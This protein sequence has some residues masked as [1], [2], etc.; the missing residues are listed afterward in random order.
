LFKIINIFYFIKT[1]SSAD[2]AGFIHDA[3]RLADVGK[4]AYSSALDMIKYVKR[5][6]EYVPWDTAASVLARID[7]MFSL[8]SIFG[9]W[10]VSYSLLNFTV[11]SAVE[12][13]SIII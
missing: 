3:F 2:R 7:N 1:F 13:I 8:G 5:E 12:N 6:T 9:Q 11:F 10:R 4:L